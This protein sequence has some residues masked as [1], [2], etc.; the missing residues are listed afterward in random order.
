MHETPWY[1]IVGAVLMG[2]G[3]AT[4]ALRH[5][6]C[7]TAM[8]Y[9]VLGIALGPAGT[10]LLRLD[11]ERDAPLLRSIVEVALLVSLFAIGLRLRVPPSDRLWR[12]PCRV[13]LL[14]MSVTVP[15]LAM[16]TMR[17]AVRASSR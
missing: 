10:G 7:S 16:L 15:L 12:V 1:L 11:L 3:I 14:A 8:I 9:L 6:P 2:M 5:L 13:G 17:R 4:S